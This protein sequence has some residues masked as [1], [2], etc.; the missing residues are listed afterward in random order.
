MA[1]KVLKLFL[2]SVVSLFIVFISSNVMAATITAKVDGT[3]VKFR[4]APSTSATIIKKLSNVKVTVTDKKSGWYKVTVSNQ[5]GWIKSNYIKLLTTSG[6]INSN[7][8]NF[9]KSSSTSSSKI[10]ILKKGTSVQ[11]LDTVKGWHKVKIGT[12]IGYV[13][14]RFVSAKALAV[15]TLAAKSSR[16]SNS[17]ALTS[18]KG[19]EY[20]LSD[21]IV[22]Y[23]KEFVGVKYVYGGSTPGGFDCS[24]FIGYVYKKF[25]IKLN[26]SAEDLYLNGTRVSKSELQPGDILFFD[27]SSRKASG[28]IDHAGIYLGGGNFIHASSSNGEVRIQKLSEYKGTYIGAKRV[29]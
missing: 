25:G 10:A 27:A 29:I 9:R 17:V 13:A 8:V 28:I 21:Q 7:G 14:S 2:T 20:S 12:K 18:V 19:L 11:I 16:S 26:R 6:T 22:E 1:K 3:D 4:K 24:G 5:T 15:S 23:S